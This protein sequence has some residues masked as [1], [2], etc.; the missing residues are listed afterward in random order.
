[1]NNVLLYDQINKEVNT[2]IN[3]AD[4]LVML[5]IA[6][7]VFNQEWEY[8]QYRKVFRIEGSDMGCGKVYTKFYKLYVDATPHDIVSIYNY[9]HKSDYIYDKGNNILIT[10][11]VDTAV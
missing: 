7:K 6:N 11:P 10:K 9:I 2:Y 1:M 8:Y 5:D 3:K 4:V